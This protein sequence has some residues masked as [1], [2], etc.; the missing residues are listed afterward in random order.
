MNLYSNIIFAHAITR[1][2]SKEALIMWAL[3]RD[4]VQTKTFANKA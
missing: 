3:K 4:K 2:N 1:P